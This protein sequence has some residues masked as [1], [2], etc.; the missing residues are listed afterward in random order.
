MTLIPLEE[1][2][3]DTIFPRQWRLARVEVVNWGTFDG[4]HSVDI[5]RKG[6]LFTGMSGSGKSTLLDAITAVLTP[7][8]SVTFNAAAQDGRGRS[9]DRNWVSYVRGAW[10]READE[11]QDRTVAKFLR[12]NATWSGI[13]LR[14]E[15]GVSE[16]LNL[17]ALFHMRGA[18]VSPQDLRELY[19]ISQGE[20]TLPDYAAYVEMGVDKRRLDRERK[21]VIST[22][23]GKHR[24]FYQR[25]L[26]LFGLRS[27]TALL[28]L[29]RTQAAKNLGTLDNLLRRFML[30]EPKS[31][32]LADDAV[33]KFG[34]LREAYDHVVE[35]RHQ[36]DALV[37]LV[38]SADQA[39]ASQKEADA[40]RLQREHVHVY[41]DNLILR[42]AKED[43][44]KAKARRTL[45]ASRLKGKVEALET[46]EALAQAAQERL[47]REGGGSV[48]SAQERVSD[49]ERE[50]RRTEGRRKRRA[51]DL[52]RVGISMPECEAEYEEL[53]SEAG[54]QLKLS[55][56]AQIP[57]ELAQRSANARAEV[58][59]LKSDLETLLRH[60]S[61]IAKPLLGVRRTL[62]E[63]LGI[64][65]ALL[66]F[67]AELISVKDQYAPWR[68]AIERVLRPL[69]TTL[70]VRDQDMKAVRRA[71]DG[72]NLGLNLTIQAV[73]ASSP[74][75]RP[76]RDPRSLV[77]RVTVSDSEFR[78]GLLYTLSARYDYACVDGPDQLGQV[79]RGLT[80]KG[81]V[82]QS[83]RRYVKADRYAIDRADHWILGGDTEPKRV[84]L[85]SR[86]E[87]ALKEQKEAAAAHDKATEARDAELARRSVYQSIVDSPWSDVDV[88]AARER[89]RRLQAALNVLT[90]PNS[91][92]Q[93]AAAAV[94][95][96]NLRLA[97]AAEEKTVEEKELWAADQQCSELEE[98]IHDLDRTPE[99]PPDLEQGLHDL[100][101][102]DRRVLTREEVPRFSRKVDR[103]LQ[104]R[105][106]AA[107]SQVQS[108]STRFIS[109]ANS[110]SN[111]WPTAA[112]ELT[113][114]LADQG[115]Y[116][117]ILAGIEERG[118]P[119]HEGNFRRLLDRQAHDDV[120][121]LLDDLKSA[122]RQI[123]MRI[124]PVNES[125]GITEFDR[126]RFLQIRV[127]PSHSQEVRDFLA[128][129]Q[130]I[131]KDHFVEED[132]AAAEER[133][134]L[135]DKV[136]RR[137]GS[138]EKGDRDWR[139]RVLD[140]RTHVSF[141][142]EEIDEG[143]AVT[144]VHDSST[145]LS[146]GQRQKLVAFCLAAALRYQLAGQDTAIPTYG[147]VVIDEAFDQSDPTYTKL[148]LDAFKEFGFHMVLATPN[149]SLQTLEPYVGGV[150]VVANPNRSGSTIASGTFA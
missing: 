55:Q 117:Q 28:L 31:L 40:L 63:E 89:V 56:P 86:L 109:L 37:K 23:T 54:A 15:D 30:E 128:Q 107:E 110:F 44:R 136:M 26:R 39:N 138:S 12:P 52:G 35:L 112:P 143:G 51:D 16:P 100:F 27:T 32:L 127:R 105:T 58:E 6:H 45:A 65:S 133:F 150:A 19:V 69:G 85:Q 101:Y 78:D 124:E 13:L 134:L 103:E 22:T 95:A 77:N 46:A 36:R 60:G 84:M 83:H 123:K 122:P 8:R 87:A 9:G 98:T 88:K 96:A 1:A 115:G 74:S 99:V 91:E 50:L 64:P 141:V 108:A 139:S 132:L 59:R 17:V 129:L 24:G 7:K 71:V 113:D 140:T 102:K 80:I 18:S 106:D 20:E 148:A 121:L 43:L 144:N 5:A 114:S 73:P 62:S 67:A 145:G 66:P 34:E 118:L 116:R 49:A 48:Q 21:P 72:R 149:K 76:A 120:V 10:G 14:F 11:L 3:G 4:F 90:A 130:L 29:H 93:Q 25:L 82:K 147:T 119:K 97:N 41:E 94:D 137:L 38:E 2:Q 131:V 70:L 61:N 142:A 53:L 81:L 42:L 125:L 135:L 146:G 68:G 57:Y 111:Q 75:P 92:L 33:E 126:Q 79:E 47:F 104:Q